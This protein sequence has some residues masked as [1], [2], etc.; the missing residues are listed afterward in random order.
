[1]GLNPMLLA[2]AT[3]VF[4]AAAVDAR[5]REVPPVTL[6]GKAQTCVPLQS[7]RE[8]RVRDD[9]TIDFY[10]RGGKVFRNTLPYSCPSLGF[11]QRF[12]YATS[13][14]QLCSTD[15][16]TV[17]QSPNIMRGATCGLGQFQPVTGAPR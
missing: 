13:L 5:P 2:A 1:M 10:M 15:T 3:I 7:I 12:A 4:T 9:R 6:A 14:S 17:L 16:I 8:T 11:E